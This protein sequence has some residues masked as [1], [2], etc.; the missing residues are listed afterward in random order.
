MINDEIELIEIKETKECFICL[1]DIDNELF[2]PLN[3]IKEYSKICHCNGNIHKSCLDNW[4][5][6]NQKCP[7]CRNTMIKN[8]ECIIKYINCNNTFMC[9]YTFFIK[10]LLFFIIILRFVFVVF[11]I[12]IISDKVIIF[13]HSNLRPMNETLHQNYYDYYNQSIIYHYEKKYFSFFPYH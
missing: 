2:I 13:Y 8:P 12:F 11:I 1:E 6:I 5:V 9:M 7:I 3:K 10:Y 4:Y